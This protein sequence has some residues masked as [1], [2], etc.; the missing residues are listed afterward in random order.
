[1]KVVTPPHLPVFS[2]SVYMR[3]SV[4]PTSSSFLSL[5]HGVDLRRKNGGS[6]AGFGAFFV[7][8]FF[9]SKESERAFVR[10]GKKK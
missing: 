8:F 7:S 3:K 9:F 1:M 6:E 4:S 2:V 10:A 5:V